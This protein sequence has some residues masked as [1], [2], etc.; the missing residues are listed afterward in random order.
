MAQNSG[1]CNGEQ[2]KET[3]D[4]DIIVLDLRKARFLNRTR[5]KERGFENEQ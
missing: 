4:D 2:Q 5:V 1:R 3:S